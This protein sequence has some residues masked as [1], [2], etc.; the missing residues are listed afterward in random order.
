MLKPG[1]KAPDFNALS[2][3]GESV[4]LSEYL[5]KGPVILYFYP[6]DNSPGCTTE[7]IS[8]RESW[9]RIRD[10]GA[11]VIGVSS[12]DVESHRGFKSSCSLP[13]TLLS[14]VGSKIRKL[15]GVTGLLIPPRVTFVID[16]N[17]IIRDVYSSQLMVKSH[18]KRAVEVLTAL[19]SEKEPSV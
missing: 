17:G 7:A 3:S 11:D 15:Y 1:D 4:S 19:K 12:D 9:N 5:K 16:N 18:V 14:D 8:F 13:F 10:L 6:K 2:D